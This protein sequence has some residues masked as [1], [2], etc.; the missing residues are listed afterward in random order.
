[1]TESHPH[2]LSGEEC[3]EEQTRVVEEEELDEE[4]TRLLDEHNAKVHLQPERDLIVEL[5]NIIGRQLELKEEWKKLPN[6]ERN[7]MAGAFYNAI[8]KHSSARSSDKVLDDDNDFKC[9]DFLCT[10]YPC[11]YCIMVSH[12]SAK[13]EKEKM[14][15]D[16]DMMIIALKKKYRKEPVVLDALENVEDEIL[17]LQQ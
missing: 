9:G 17:A 13:V 8:K 4:L 1:M 11:P 7:V 14:L 15:D 3:Y 5:F 12:T 2:C 16:V 6:A 10:K